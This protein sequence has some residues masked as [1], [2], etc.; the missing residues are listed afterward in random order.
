MGVR[1]PC[2]SLVPIVLDLRF[3]GLDE[4]ADGFI[5][6]GMVRQIDTLWQSQVHPE[7]HDSR[8]LIQCL[9]DGALETGEVLPNE[10]PLLDHY[11]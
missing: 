4:S 3:E 7:R 11:R 1:V 9:V 6:I 10:R 5:R 8:I 2:T